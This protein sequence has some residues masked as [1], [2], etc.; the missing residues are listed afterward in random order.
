MPALRVSIPRSVR[1]PSARLPARSI[2]ESCRW[3]PS[4]RS[5]AGLLVAERAGQRSL[6]RS[7]NVLEDRR[8]VGCFRH[9]R[10]LKSALGAALSQRLLFVM[11]VVGFVGDKRAA[12]AYADQ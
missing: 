9:Y 3:R 10:E 7:V 6:H 2:R 5:D 8:A 1:R 11:Q 4:L 12:G